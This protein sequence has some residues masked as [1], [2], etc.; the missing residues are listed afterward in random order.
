MIHMNR[1]VLTQSADP[2]LN[3]YTHSAHPL[4]KSRMMLSQVAC[5]EDEAFV[6]GWCCEL[7]KLRRYREQVA[8][9]VAVLK[10]VSLESGAVIFLNKWL[11][12]RRL[13]G[14]KVKWPGIASA[15]PSSPGAH[16]G[17]ARSGRRR[18]P[19]RTGQAMRHRRAPSVVPPGNRENKTTTIFTQWSLRVDQAYHD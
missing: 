11:R 14:A 15:H 16:P 4:N 10:K 5:S 2:V 8:I 7:T 3:Q 9:S 17:R 13:S 19:A 18:S 6:E 1:Y 12:S